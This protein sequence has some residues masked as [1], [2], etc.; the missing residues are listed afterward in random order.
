MKKSIIENIKRQF[1]HHTELTEHALI[2]RRIKAGFTGLYVWQTVI[3]VFE[4]QHAITLITQL[5]RPVN[6]GGKLYHTSSI[7]LRK[8]DGW[9]I[10]HAAFLDNLEPLQPKHFYLRYKPQVRELTDQKK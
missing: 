3:M 10:A 4:D 5:E 9:I 8:H 6:W 1:Q 7:V 2:D